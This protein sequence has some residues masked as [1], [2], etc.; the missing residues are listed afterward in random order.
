MK[1]EELRPLRIG[2]E[3]RRM[4]FEGQKPQPVRD[5]LLVRA[6]RI[7]YVIFYGPSC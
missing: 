7:P 6:Y 5:L 3:E 1:D 4:S 2:V